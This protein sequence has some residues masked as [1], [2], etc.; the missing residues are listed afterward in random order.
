VSQFRL[1]FA[2]ALLALTCAAAPAL[3]QE[4]AAPPGQIQDAVGGV[5]LAAFIP[6]G[7]LGDFYNLGFGGFVRY[8]R[9]L[10]PNFAW[11]GRIGYLRGIAKE[12]TLQ[13]GTSST[14]ISSAL[15]NITLRLGGVYRLSG[16]PN[17]LFL[18][19]ELG[20]NLLSGRVTSGTTSTTG[21]TKAKF[22]AGVGAGFRTG[23]LSFRV[24]LD[25]L[26]LTEA[27]KTMGALVSV[28]WDLKAL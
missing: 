1:V 5:D 28:G 14:T 25:L 21:D 18:S 3:A 6:V 20:A 16:Q 2:S 8:E 7:D 24:A 11:T 22:G 13:F 9:K 15:D 27:A 12:S 26:D 23:A 17:G 19:G 4:P 10:Q